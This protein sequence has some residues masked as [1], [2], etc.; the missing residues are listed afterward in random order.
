MYADTKLSRFGIFTFGRVVAFISS[1]SP[2]T[3]F[4]NGEVDYDKLIDTRFLPD[5]LKKTK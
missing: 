1:V 5:D 4:K 3:P 2:I